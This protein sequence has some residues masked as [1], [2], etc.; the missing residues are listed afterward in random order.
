FSGAELG[1]T[2]IAMLNSVQLSDRGFGVPEFPVVSEDQVLIVLAWL[3]HSVQTTE[4]RL[5]GREKRI[6]EL[7]ASFGVT[8]GR[9]SNKD[10]RDIQL[11]QEAQNKEV[12]K[13]NE[14]FDRRFSSFIEAQ[15]NLVFD[16]K[17]IYQEL[18]KNPQNKSKEK[19]LKSKI[20][21]VKIRI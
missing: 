13:Y 14:N 10:R 7:E 2:F 6:T 9:E 11:L 8:E 19:N 3:W 5:K 4:Q 15:R 17:N 20:D 16:I 18:N 12:L 21:K 1:R